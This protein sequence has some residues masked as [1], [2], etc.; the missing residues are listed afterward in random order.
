MI[1]GVL[2]AGQLARMLCES[3]Y[4]MGVEPWV[5][6]LKPEVQECAGLIAARVVNLKDTAEAS[7]AIRVCRVV[8]Y[9]SEFLPVERIQALG[10]AELFRPGLSS[11]RELQD[12][13][14]QKRR[15][16]AV[17]IPTADWI[18]P[19][20]GEGAPAFLTRAAKAFGKGFVLKWS[21]QGYDGKGVKLLETAQALNPTPEVLDFVARGTQA[22]GIVYAEQRIAFKRELAQIGVRS[23]K[24]E[25]ALY[26]PVVS[27]QREGI[28]R[29][30][31]GPASA[32]GVKRPQLARMGAAMTKL[33]KEL[34]W[35][36][37]LAIE[38]FEDTR[39]GLFVNEIAPRVHNSGHYTQDASQTSQFENHWR[40]LLGHPLGPTE[41]AKFFG[42]FNVLGPAGIHAK[43]NVAP[44]PPPGT[45]L[46]HYAKDAVAPGRKLGHLNWVARTRQASG[47]LAKRAAQAETAW[48]KRLTLAK[49]ASHA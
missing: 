17:G 43:T 2:G 48:A 28:C 26:P 29:L 8:T 12:K 6:T 7:E 16:Q 30:V 32:Y 35:E 39:G 45:H 23:R 14:R 41:S 9:E 31:L 27:E 21:Q 24:G 1:A 25:I 47:A 36:G 40:A 4:A 18:E 15:L 20:A 44:T 38:W 37:A 49:D 10:S 34:K 33:L 22:G 42:M 5:F 19:Q 3:A 46:H 11:L 13:C